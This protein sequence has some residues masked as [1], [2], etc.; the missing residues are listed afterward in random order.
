MKKFFTLSFAVAAAVS[1]CAAPQLSSL[2]SVEKASPKASVFG[3]L[4]RNDVTGTI[5]KNAKTDGLTVKA[6]PEGA[7]VTHYAAFPYGSFFSNNS[8]TMNGQSGYAYPIMLLPAYAENEWENCSFYATDAGYQSAVNEFSYAWNYQNFNYEDATAT[9]SVLSV[10]NQPSD[11]YFYCLKGWM[12]DAPALTVGTDSVYMYTGATVYGGKGGLPEWF[13]TMNG[14]TDVENMGVYPFNIYSDD[15]SRVTSAG[16]FGLASN[17]ADG[18][19]KQG[20]TEAGY[21]DFSVL[22]IAQVIAKPV[23]PYAL[24]SVTVYAY[25]DCTA[26]AELSLTFYKVGEDGSLTVI[27]EATHKFAE[28]FSSAT[29]GAYA[30]IPVKFTTE[31][32]YGFEID[33]QLI[34]HEILMVVSG[35]DNGGFTNF[36]IPAAWAIMGTGAEVIEPLGLYGLCSYTQDGSQVAGLKT[37]PYYLAFNSAPG[38]YVYPSSALISLD[39]EYPYLQTFYDLVS[40]KAVEAKSE[41][42][43]NLEAG[44]YIFYGLYC[45]GAADDIVISD[46]P[47]WLQVEIS[48]KTQDVDGLTGE[49]VEVG[50]AV[51]DNATNVGES[52]DIVLDYKGSKQT[53]HITHAAAGVES[54]AKDNVEVVAVEYYNIQGQKLNAAPEN[55]IFIQKNIKADGSISNVKVVK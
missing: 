11:P 40:N 5:L 23:V 54:I 10:M 42:S 48:D 26:G 18:F 30:E 32:E 27:K 15:Y 24:S 21:T 16:L 46:Y 55:G 45:S 44:G 9:G 43:I 47:E 29:A 20:Y 4:T 49:Y 3:K 34:D 50:F 13:S 8:F 37:F 25:V 6:I 38:E 33:Y 36:D 52:C 22:G 53:F 12:S 35:Y 41:Y 51:A 28:A 1:V 31:D 19:W 2:A 7:T 17:D 39:M 14:L